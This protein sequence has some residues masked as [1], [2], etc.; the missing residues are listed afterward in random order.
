M[1]QA[2]SQDR[3]ANWVALQSQPLETLFAMLGRSIYVAYNVC[4]WLPSYVWWG[5]GVSLPE[6]QAP[7]FCGL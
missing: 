1:A 5:E 7:V 6:M 4:F 2:F 3:L